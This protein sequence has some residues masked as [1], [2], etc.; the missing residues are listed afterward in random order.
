MGIFINKIMKVLSL[1]AL[2]A[3]V[4]EAN[5][6]L[7]TVYWASEITFEILDE[8]GTQLCKGGPY[9]ENGVEYPVLGCSLP[10]VITVKC[11]DSYGDGWHGG[12]L[13]IGDKEVCKDFRS[14]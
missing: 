2:L 10:T 9:R 13:Q 11:Y 6:S 14:G 8:S 3:S 7:H 5:V 1:F 12:Y 4:A